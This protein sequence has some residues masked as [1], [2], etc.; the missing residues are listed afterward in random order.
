MGDRLEGAEKTCQQQQRRMQAVAPLCHSVFP[1]PSRVHDHKV[2]LMSSY[3]FLSIAHNSPAGAARARLYPGRNSF[4]HER[5]EDMKYFTRVVRTHKIEFKQ[6]S[7]PP[8]FQ[9]VACC[10]SRS[11]SRLPILFVSTPFPLR[12]WSYHAFVGSP[13]DDET[14]CEFDG[15]NQTNRAS[16]PAFSSG[17][18]SRGEESASESEVSPT[19]LVW[20]ESGNTTGGGIECEW[21]SLPPSL[22]SYVSAVYFPAGAAA[23]VTK[24]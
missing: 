23:N 19:S 18:Q 24:E 7:F 22:N 14:E 12:P 5:I 16:M 17:R 4:S 11:L 9:Y 15:E 6:Y 1:P 2:M 8:L 3:T 21:L 10:L 20:M 13:R